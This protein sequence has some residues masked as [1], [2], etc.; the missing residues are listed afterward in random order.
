[1]TGTPQVVTAGEIAA[2]ACDFVHALQPGAAC[3][4]TDL[5]RLT[6]LGGVGLNLV[7][8]AAGG[9]AFPHHRHHVEDEWTY[10]L[11][12]R[13]T[14]RIGEATHALGPGDFVAF[15]AGGDAHSVQNASTVEPLVCLMG[16]LRVAADIVDFP[17]LGMRVTRSGLGVETAE[18]TAFSPFRFNAAKKGKTR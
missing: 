1:M 8:V 13:A 12:G 5:A 18:A 3:R 15:P 9:Q 6:A 17:E 14:V 7:T 10:V 16:G 2:A 11:A 4:L